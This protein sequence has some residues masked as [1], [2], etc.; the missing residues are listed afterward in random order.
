[1]QETWETWV[2]FLGQ[3]DPLEEGMATYSSI[4]TCRIPKTEEPGRLQSIG[5]YRVTHDWSNLAHSMHF[6]IQFIFLNVYLFFSVLYI[7]R[8]YLC[9]VYSCSLFILYSTICYC[10][11]PHCLFIRHTSKDLWVF[12]IWS[13]Y[14]CEQWI[15]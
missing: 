1:M 12:P 14:C 9:Y 2:Q 3:E 5:S 11:V 13:F 8:I 4:L 6:I 7:Y 10:I 15:F